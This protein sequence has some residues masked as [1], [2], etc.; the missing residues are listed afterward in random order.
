MAEILAKYDV[1]NL[2]CILPQ[3][4]D[5]CNDNYC[6]FFHS[7]LLSMNDNKHFKLFNSNDLLESHYLRIYFL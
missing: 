4:G 2:P 7:Y 1:I 3:K 5:G 6:P